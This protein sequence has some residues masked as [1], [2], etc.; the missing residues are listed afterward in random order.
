MRVTDRTLVAARRGGAV[1][2]FALAAA[3]SAP[4]AHA[5]G[6]AGSSALTLAEVVQL[7][8]SGV[9][10]TQ[11]V[12]TARDYCIAFTVADTAERALRVAGA[13]SALLAEL[14]IACRPAGVAPARPATPAPSAAIVDDDFLG[15]RRL[16]ENVL[17]TQSCRGRYADGGFVLASGD[18]QLGCTVGYP[19]ELDGDVRIEVNLSMLDG[20]DATVAVGFGRDRYSWDRWSFIVQ[21]N[22]RFELCRFEGARCTRLVPTTSGATAW[23]RTQRADNSLVIEIRGRI[24]QLYLNDVRV[25]ESL[26]Q[27]SAAG[28]VVLGVGPR[29]S[30]LFKRLRITRPTG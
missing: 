14:R 10:N 13:D 17:R 27:G 8:R 1:M 5:Q 16:P 6:S 7:R 12:Q 2:T 4:A 18:G 22:G 21:A 3:V 29:S 23:R 11:I 26:L 15:T 25:A 9:P 30:V 20:P 24:L 19:I 28:Q